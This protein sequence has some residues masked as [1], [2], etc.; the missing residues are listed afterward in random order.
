MYFRYLLIEEQSRMAAIEILELSELT[1]DAT[2]SPQQMTA[3]CQRL[4]DQHWT[5]LSSLEGCRVRISHYYTV[6][7]DGQ[8]CIPWD[9]IGNEWHLFVKACENSIEISIY[10]ILKFACVYKIVYC[11]I[12]NILNYSHNMPIFNF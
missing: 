2:V 9:W 10:N 8:I 11:F 5:F 7:Q 4:V 6:M 1:K 12:I 3:C